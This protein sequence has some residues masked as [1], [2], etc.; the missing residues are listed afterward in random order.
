MVSRVLATAAVAVV[1][2][3]AV[4]AVLDRAGGPGD[5]G[6]RRVSADSP[7]TG[8]PATCARQSGAS[9][10][11]AFASRDNLVIGPLAM[12]GAGRSTSPATVEEFGGQ[13][14]P[15]LIRPRHTVTVAVSGPEGSASLFYASGGGVLTERRVRD[16]HRKIT[17]RPCGPRRAQSDVNGDPVTFWSGFVLVSGPMCVRLK[18][19][20]DGHRKPRREHIAVGRSC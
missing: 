3:L 19:W 6:P 5:G 13:K 11:R 17:F 9:F 18:V 16:G 2:M 1:L 10:P 15:A 12:V 14:Y 8:Y 7:H 4:P 20:I